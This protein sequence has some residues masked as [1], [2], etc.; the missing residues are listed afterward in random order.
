M[1]PGNGIP[2][3]PSPRM[4]T[5]TR[6]CITRSENQKILPADGSISSE[7]RPCLYC[8]GCRRVACRST[9]W[10]IFLQA[11]INKTRQKTSRKLTLYRRQ[12]KTEIY[13]DCYCRA[14][15]EFECAC[16]CTVINVH[17]GRA[18]G[19][20]NMS[21]ECPARARMSLLTRA[22]EH[23]SNHALRLI[24]QRGWTAKRRRWQR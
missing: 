3:A 6:S 24:D 5:E 18:F 10:Y 4:R 16:A 14:T 12:V 21:L 2:Y 20:T 11:K 23:S 13:P 15:K 9:V 22:L 7:S 19:V 1:L 17:A 8:D